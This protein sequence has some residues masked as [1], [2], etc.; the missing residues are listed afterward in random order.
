MIP[1]RRLYEYFCQAPLPASLLRALA[2]HP[3]H[4]GEQQAAEAT[5][6]SAVETDELHIGPHTCLDQR[7]EG[8]DG[9]SGEVRAHGQ[10]NVMGMAPQEIV[11]G[12]PAPLRLL[13]PS[14]HAPQSGSRP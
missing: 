12:R 10:V 5:D 13:G 7:D 14:P 6:Q 9:K 4:K 11:D 2:Q 3:M 1:S 8:D